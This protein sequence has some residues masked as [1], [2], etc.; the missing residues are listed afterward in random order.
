MKHGFS[1]EDCPL[2]AAAPPGMFHLG[3]AKHNGCGEIL[4]RQ[5]GHPSHTDAL[6]ADGWTP[7]YARTDKS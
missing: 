1:D 5:A 4:F 2:C 6:L 3:V 7:I